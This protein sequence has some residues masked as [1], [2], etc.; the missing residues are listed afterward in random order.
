M[1]WKTILFYRMNVAKNFTIFHTKA[2]SRNRSRGNFSDACC[3]INNTIPI[4]TRT[5]EDSGNKCQHQLHCQ[6]QLQYQ[7]R[8]WRSRKILVLQ[9]S[10]FFRHASFFFKILIVVRVIPYRAKIFSAHLNCI[11]VMLVLSAAIN[12]IKK[13]FRLL[14]PYEWGRLL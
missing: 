12:S 9:I 3:E 14:C 13:K 11:Q 5:T 10:K 2:F 4:G 6:R 8:N 7:L 1:L